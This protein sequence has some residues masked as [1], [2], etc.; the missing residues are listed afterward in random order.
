MVVLIYSLMK[1]KDHFGAQEVSR[2]KWHLNQNFKGGQNIHQCRWV[3]VFLM[4]D[5]VC[6]P[7]EEKQGA[8][9]NGEH[10]DLA[11]PVSLNLLTY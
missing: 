3:E 2:K 10:S 5:D 9:G 4:G 6:R 7:R 8:W 11:S 1:L